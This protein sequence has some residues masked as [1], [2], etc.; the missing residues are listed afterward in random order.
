MILSSRDESNLGFGDFHDVDSW[1]V[2]RDSMPLRSAGPIT[3]QRLGLGDPQF[4]FSRSSLDSLIVL[5]CWILIYGVLLWRDQIVI[6]RTCQVH[7]SIFLADLVRQNYWR[8][9]SALT[10]KQDTKDTFEE[11]TFTLFLC[12]RPIITQLLCRPLFYFLFC[13]CSRSGP[14]LPSASLTGR[15][16]W[17]DC[18]LYTWLFFWAGALPFLH[19]FHLTRLWVLN[20][21]KKVPTCNQHPGTCAVPLIIAHANFR[22]FELRW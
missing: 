10:W 9:V 15:L 19:L 11:N 3:S 5:L 12:S 14:C 18:K 16:I 1:P 20:G 8:H 13:S 2:A 22:S 17:T 21:A 6:V 7:E 4:P